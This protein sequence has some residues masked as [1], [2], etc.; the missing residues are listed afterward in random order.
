[1][2]ELD[3]KD[4]VVTN[5]DNV[6]VCCEIKFVSGVLWDGG[7]ST[8]VKSGQER[9]TSLNIANV[10]MRHSQPLVRVHAKRRTADVLRFQLS[11]KMTM[12]T[13]ACK[14]RR[15]GEQFYPHARLDK[16]P[17]AKHGLG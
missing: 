10:R 12:T 13:S 6:I 15:D 4:S 2:R 5:E 3:L 9:I 17:K 1:V 8:G 16:C 14:N 11:I 7:I